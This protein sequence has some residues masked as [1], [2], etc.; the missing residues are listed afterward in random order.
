MMQ[1]YNF[2]NNL[3]K[4]SDFISFWRSGSWTNFHG[5]LYIISDLLV[6]S[7]Y[8]IIPVIILIYVRRQGKKLHFNNLYVLF[9]TFIL[10]SGATYFIDAVMFWLPLFRLSA[11]MRFITAIISWVTIFCLIKI[12][13]KVLSLKS[14]QEL[15]EEIDRRN[16]VEQTLKQKNERL[17]EAEQT[18][19]LGNCYWDILRKRVELS[20]M[21]YTIL[22][23]PTGAIINKEKLLE[24]IHPADIRFVED[25]LKK[26]LKARS[27]QEFY[28]RVVTQHMI[29]KHVLVKGEVVRNSRGEPAVVKGT[30]QDVSELR[31]HMQRI[32]MQN[33]RL[34]KIAWVQSHRMRSPVATIL[35]MVELF[36]VEDPSDPMN[37]EIINNVKE[38]TQ[39][40]DSMIH[41]VDQLTREH[42]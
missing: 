30:I 37:G 3:F 13:P 14:P 31:R 40:L 8:F 6:W 23:L 34:K 9:A 33:K 28:F 10:V 18:A 29:V 26:N 11:L 24:Q 22:G 32:E 15:Q 17:N 1:L 7:A 12:L 19:K 20:E 27:F 4:H 25:S 2:L 38:L 36:N 5:W 39:K 35:G 21:A 41:E 42:R 16:E